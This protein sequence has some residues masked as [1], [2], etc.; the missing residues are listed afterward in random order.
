MRKSTKATRHDKSAI[1]LLSGGLDSTVCLWW[2]KKQEYSRID[3]LTFEYG[4][5][6]EKV[7]RAT[8]E[9]LAELAQISQ[10]QSITLDFL[11]RFSEQINSSLAQG[12]DRS[13]PQLSPTELDDLATSTQSAHSV[14]IPA[15]NLVFLSIA[16]AYAETIGGQVAL[17]TGFNLEEGT[18]FPDNTEAFIDDFTRTASRGVLKAEIGVVCPLKGMTKEE[19]VRLGAQLEVPFAYSTSCYDP[20]GFDPTGKPIHCGICESC[21]RRKRGFQRSDIDDPTVYQKEI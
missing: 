10:H 7:L 13:L 21:L 16:A 8:A 20:Q 2:A 1:V 18:T 6:E 3:C 14:W 11:K 12:S 4:S 5:K 15:R 9:K 17:I 19:I